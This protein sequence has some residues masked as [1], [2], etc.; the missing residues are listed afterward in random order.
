[1]LSSLDLGRLA[2]ERDLHLYT[3]MPQV[4][5]MRLRPEPDENCELA[6]RILSMDMYA[7][8]RGSPLAQ[9]TSELKRCMAGIISSSPQMLS[10]TRPP[11]DRHPRDPQTGA[12]PGRHATMTPIISRLVTLQAEA[13]NDTS[14]LHAIAPA[15]WGALESFPEDAL[16]KVRDRRLYRQYLE[17]VVAE[18]FKL[19]DLAWQN[20]ALGV[21]VAQTAAVQLKI[22]ANL[23]P[24]TEDL[25]LSIL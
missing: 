4:L 5:A 11:E 13:A 16:A 9:L 24:G 17:K 21:S 20:N 1:M 2:A 10:H 7:R 19:V 6:L 15:A 12:D 23:P 25:R 14:L 3:E 8:R 22:L 18:L